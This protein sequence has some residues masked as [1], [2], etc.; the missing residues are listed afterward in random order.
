[1]VSIHTEHPFATPDDAK[2][3]VRR[4]RGRLPAPVTI[5]ATGSERSRVG[6]TVSSALIVEPQH[7][8]FVVNELTDLADRLTSGTPLAVSILEAGDS[9]YSEV[10]AGLAPAP[11]GMFTVGTWEQSQWGPRLQ[12]HSWCGATVAEIRALG[13]S[14][15]VTATIETIELTEADAAIHARGAW[16]R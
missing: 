3:V 16:L 1:V 13:W 2:S 15:V 6:L 14:H 4:L 10:F 5:I 7:L 12:G 9:R 8:V 11:G